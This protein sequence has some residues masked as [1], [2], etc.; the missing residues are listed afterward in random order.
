M[1][2]YILYIC[3]TLMDIDMYIILCLAQNIAK[4]VLLHAPRQQKGMTQYLVKWKDLPYDQA[5]WE[6]VDEDSYFPYVFS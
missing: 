3:T 5:T 1:L 6:F 2:V 4:Y